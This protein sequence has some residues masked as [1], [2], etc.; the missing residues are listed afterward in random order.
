VRA[1]KPEEIGRAEEILR[2][3]EPISITYFDDKGHIEQ[4]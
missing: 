2:T 3:N 4:R 1:N